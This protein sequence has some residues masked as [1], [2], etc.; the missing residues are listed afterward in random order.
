M[1]L[2][3]YTSGQGLFGIFNSS[4]LHCSNINFLNDPSEQ[5][6]FS[7]ILKAVFLESSEAEN[8][9]NTLFNQPYMNAVVEPFDIFIASF[10]RNSDSLS[11]WNYYAKGNGYNI[12]MDIDE[13]INENKKNTNL[14]I[15]KIELIYNKSIQI[16]ETTEFLI[17][18]KDKLKQFEI[19]SEKQKSPDIEE[20]E[21][22]GL[23]QDR[24][25]ITEDF[26]DKL[27]KLRLRYKHYA[28][29]REE[30]VRLIISE[31]EVEQKT[32]RFKVLD[33]G[34]FVEYFALEINLDNN[35]RSVTIHPLNGELHLGGVTKFTRSMMGY[36]DLMQIRVSLIPFRNV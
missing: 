20:N 24:L 30:E 18:Y 4:E 13:I 2:Y 11:M 9:Y 19:M 12:G 17:S 35:I 15:Q 31:N 5:S 10:S 22:H 27:Y 6:Y 16:K 1:I 21:Y 23:E 34:V 36:N 3:H 33:S 7:E 26:N 32:T 8:I 28:Y 25:E 14:S 29:E